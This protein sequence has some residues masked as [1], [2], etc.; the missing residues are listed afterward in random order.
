MIITTETYA[1]ALEQLTALG[2]EPLQ[3][4]AFTIAADCSAAADTSCSVADEILG[5]YDARSSRELGFEVVNAAVE[6]A[7]EHFSK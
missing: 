4:L 3:L 2:I 5:V 7:K 6:I 1:K